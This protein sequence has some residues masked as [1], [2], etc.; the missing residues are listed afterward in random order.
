VVL[1]VVGG[2]LVLVSAAADR[3]GMGGAPGFGWKQIVGVGLGVV[4]VVAGA[5]SLLRR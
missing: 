2:L 4:L 1:L 5:A 3:L